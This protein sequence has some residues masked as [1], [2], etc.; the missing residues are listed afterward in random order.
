MCRSAA[1]L[2]S[3]ELKLPAQVSTVMRSHRPV[4]LRVIGNV[5]QRKA[6]QAKGGFTLGPVLE[7]R[8]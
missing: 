4:A 5:C 2:V 3:G 6:V 8:G 7:K 1:S